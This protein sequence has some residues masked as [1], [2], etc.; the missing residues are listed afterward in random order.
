MSGE[1][2]V[3]LLLAATVMTGAGY[4][5]AFRFVIRAR[6]IEDTP[7]AKIR[8][9]PQGYIELTGHADPGPAGALQSPLTGTACFWY[10]YSVQR[11]SGKNWVTEESD[12]ST[13]PF[14]LIDD[15]GECLVYP[16]KAEVTPGLSRSWQGGSRAA[17]HSPTG[18]TFTVSVFGRYRF[19][20]KLI[21]QDDP[22]YALGFFQTH[23]GADQRPSEAKLTR[24]MLNLWKQDKA[25]LLKRFDINNDGTIDM[26]EW[27]IARRAASSAA[28]REAEDWAPPAS[29]H[30]LSSTGTGR[31]P[32]L[33]SCEEQFALATRYRRLA[34]GAIILFFAGVGLFVYALPDLVRFLNS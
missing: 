11:K 7:T 4:W 10:H 9:A 21:R 34:A 13:E 31:H 27:E 20:E 23:D 17:G 28:R 22:L 8:S 19:E 33:I 29:Y 18:E 24:D 5:L 30:S 26:K 32:F 25:A 14:K 15:T 16:A 3:K 6:I 1:E 12:T 2:L